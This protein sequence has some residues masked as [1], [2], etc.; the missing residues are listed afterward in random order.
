MAQISQFGPPI[1]LTK[2]ATFPGQEGP[3]REWRLLCRIWM[4]QSRT[5]PPSWLGIMTPLPSLSNTGCTRGWYAAHAAPLLGPFAGAGDG[6]GGSN[7]QESEE[8]SGTCVLMA[9]W[10]SLWAGSL[11]ALSTV[12]MLH[13]G[14]ARAGSRPVR[15][16][17]RKSRCTPQT[18]DECSTH[19]TRDIV[20]GPSMCA[21]VCVCVCVVHHFNVGLTRSLHVHCPPAARHPQGFTCGRWRVRIVCVC[22]ARVRDN[23][24]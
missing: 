15:G 3:T 23:P 1:S 4:P 10:V 22:W 11:N 12:S 14:A 9:L 8:H 2:S 18:D 6:G 19:S 13:R 20:A 21:R 5:D 7:R 24:L 17:T 16:D